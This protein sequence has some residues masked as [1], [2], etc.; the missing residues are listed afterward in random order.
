MKI[1]TFLPLLVAVMA[2]PHGAQAQLPKLEQKTAFCATSVELVGKRDSSDMYLCQTRDYTCGAYLKPSCLDDAKQGNWE[3]ASGTPKTVLKDFAN[4]PCKCVGTEYVL[5]RKATAA[6]A[7]P[8][9]NVPVAAA[10]EPVAQA[11]SA[12]VAAV[13]A[14]PAPATTA[15]AAS[16]ASDVAGLKQDNLQMRRQLEQLQRQFDELRRSLPAA[17]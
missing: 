5:T 7:A 2:L 14:V 8:A 15:P 17:K 12:P 16:L 10:V 1:Q 6:A 13:A 3:V 4:T 9:V 11:A